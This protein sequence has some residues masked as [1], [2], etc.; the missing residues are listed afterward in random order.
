MSQLMLNTAQLMVETKKNIFI[1]RESID[2]SVKEIGQIMKMTED[3]LCLN[4]RL[5][6]EKI[7]YRYDSEKIDL[8]GNQME[9]ISDQV[10]DNM[11]A[12]DDLIPLIPS[13]DIEQIEDS[14]NFIIELAKITHL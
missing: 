8:I 6:N 11:K 7:K 10:M 9:R 14:I 1:N 2:D 13:N 12:V 3:L 5:Y 4:K